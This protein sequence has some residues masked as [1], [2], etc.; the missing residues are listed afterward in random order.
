MT[1]ETVRLGNVVC[2]ADTGTWGDEAVHPHGAPVLRSSNIQDAE[3]VMRNVAWR[4]VP[5]KHRDTKR[6]ADGDLIV[7]M[8]SG[9]PA[10]IGKC[11]VFRQ[12][13]DGQE[14]YF[15]NFTLRLRARP[16]KADPKWLFYW[17][18]SPRGR[19]ILEAMNSTTSGLRNLNRSLY[20]S[21]KIPLPPLPEQRRI[22]AI[23]DKANAIRRKRQQTLDLADQFLR[24]AFLDMF[25]DPVTNSKAWPVKKL[26]EFAQIRSGI[27][28]GRKLGDVET[29]S[30]PYMRVANVQDGK[31]DLA[32]IKEIEIRPDELEKY[33]LHD[34]DIL[35]TEGGDPDKLGRGAVWTGEIDRCI[36]QNHIFSVR[37]DGSFGEPYYI[38]A[39]IGSGY[40]KRYFLRAGKQTTGIATINKT[41]LRGFPAFLPP[42]QQQRD[43]AALVTR[44]Q[45]SQGRFASIL[46]THGELLAT[47]VQRAFRGELSQRGT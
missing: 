11:C 32:V 39:L 23:L 40:G 43:Y 33:R 30:V 1:V 42:I 13:P 15:S 12:P 31:L 5:A 3:L 22:A 9:S 27:T 14:Y 8:S 25:G 41:Q 38:S 21:Q 46:D 20:L 24:S 2:L 44:F 34:G 17:L 45:E 37:V 16:E 18:S 36:H 29:I 7:T 47:L 6:L 19:S 4:E 35:L 28:K 10:H 26:G